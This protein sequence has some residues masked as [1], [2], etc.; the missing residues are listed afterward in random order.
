MGQTNTFFSQMSLTVG[1]VSVFAHV[2]IAFRRYAVIQLSLAL[3]KG[4]GEMIIEVCDDDLVFN[5]QIF[6]NNRLFKNAS[7]YSY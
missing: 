7:D 2:S 6:A 5:W 4:Y 1:R 3:S